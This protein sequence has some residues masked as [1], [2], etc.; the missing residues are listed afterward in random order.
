MPPW[1]RHQFPAA[2]ARLPGEQTADGVPRVSVRG[3]G[4]KAQRLEQSIERRNVVTP[5]H[6]PVPGEQQVGTGLA[7]CGAFVFEERQREPGVVLRIVSSFADQVAILIVLDQAV[8]RVL[9]EGEWTQH[10]RVQGRTAEQPEIR[11]RRAQ[12]RQVEVDQV[13]AEDDVRRFGEVVEFVQG[14][15]ELA[16]LEPR[17]DQGSAVGI[18]RRQRVDSLASLADLQVDGQAAARQNS[19]WQFAW[20]ACSDQGPR[21]PIGMIPTSPGFT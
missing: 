18:D 3:P 2:G 14:T 8:V 20:C 10:E 15:V 9:R 19:R 17:A 21:A 16:W 7:E 6:Q 5:R 12:V 4:R 11:C 1:V 13:V